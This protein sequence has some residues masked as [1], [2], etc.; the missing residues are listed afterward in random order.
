V[1]IMLNRLSA[2]LAAA[3]A[4]AALCATASNAQSLMDYAAPVN[5]VS[6]KIAVVSR[7]MDALKKISTEFAQSYRFASSQM[8]F[9]SP[10]KFRIDSKAGVINVKYIINGNAKVLKAGVLNKRWDITNE[11]A[12]RQSALTVGLLTPAWVNLVNASA[13][14]TRTIS[15]RKAVVFDTHFKGKK[16][17]A[18]YR[19]FMDPEKRIVLRMEQYHGDNKLKD[20]I[21][22]A[23]PVRASGI[24]VPTHTKVF[25]PL[26]QLGAVTKLENI[27]VNAGI[28]DSLFA[29]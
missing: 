23:D 6:L 1:E 25:N 2:A 16:N 18:W 3:G 8:Y 10:D 20:T 17:A 21:V 28:A 11:P 7:D 22:F 13:K 4:L 5:D 24:W 15:G 14:G 27:R 26:G 12:Q 9:K 19:L 29:L